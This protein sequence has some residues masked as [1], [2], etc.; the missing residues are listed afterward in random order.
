MNAPHLGEKSG[1]STS[2]RS[3]F[4]DPKSQP[5]IVSAISLAAASAGT[6]QQ[7][8]ASGLTH[9][10]GPGANRSSVAEKPETHPALA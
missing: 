8:L 4:S 2:G 1:S 3:F 5:H 6:L 9:S 7:N 10:P